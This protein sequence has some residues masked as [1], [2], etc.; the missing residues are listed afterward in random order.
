MLQGAPDAMPRSRT[1]SPARD[2]PKDPRTRKSRDE[3]RDK[4]H[5]RDRHKHHSKD[6]QKTKLVKT[7]DM[8]KPFS[9]TEIP[10]VPES[11]RAKRRI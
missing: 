5:D 4:S 8:N 1:P 6:S 9:F 11:W 2:K 7:V 3:G 10:S